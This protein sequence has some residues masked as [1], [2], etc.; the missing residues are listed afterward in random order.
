MPE[1][2]SQR[3]LWGR[4]IGRPLRGERQNAI[5]D[6]LPKLDLSK[7]VMQAE[8]GSLQMSDL[9]DGDVPSSAWMEIGFGGGEHVIGE[10]AQNPNIH[11]LACEPFVDGMASFLKDLLGSDYHRTRVLMDDAMLLARGLKDD[12]LDRLYILN[13]DPWHKTRHHK[14]RIVN[15]ENLDVFSRILKS[16]ADLIMSTDV[17]DLA[18]WMV[19]H[20]YVHDDFEWQAQSY[21]DWQEPPAN[22]VTTRYE[23]KKAKGASQMCYLHFKRK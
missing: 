22:W 8:D 18:D 14:R 21:R 3:R 9:F 11:Y 5:D 15:K 19:T 1:M 12:C 17:P 2:Q 20:A 23:Q 10:L 4:R 6:I 13:P 16:G 7:A